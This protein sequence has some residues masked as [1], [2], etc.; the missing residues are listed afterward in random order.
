MMKPRRIDHSQGR[1]FE[2]RLSDQLNPHHELCMLASMI[3]WDILEKEFS[4]LFDA[5]DGRG[6]KPVRLIAGLMILQHMYG[7]SDEGVVAR[8]VENP[9][10]QLFC[11]YDYLQWEFPI[12]PTTLTRW[13]QRLGEGGVEKVLTVIIDTAHAVG[14]VDNSS[15]KKVIVD[16]TVACKAISYP[17]DVNLCL[18]SLRRLVK[19]ARSENI[20]LRQTYEILGPRV[21]RRANQLFR[22]RKHKLA[23]KEVK[24]LKGYCGRVYREIL[25]AVSSNPDLEKR[26]K[27][28]FFL[29][30]QLL[31]QGQEG[32]E[33]IYSLHEPHVECISKGKVHKKYEFG[34]KASIVVTHREGLVIGAQA[35]HG[36]PYDGHTLK[37]ALEQAQTLSKQKISQAF[38]D[39][40]YRGH[41]IKDCEVMCSASKKR[42]SRRQWRDMKRRQAIEPHIGHMK[43]DGKLDRNHLTGII[44][45]KLHVLLCAIGHNVRLICNYLR[46]RMDPYPV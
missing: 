5:N 42:W 40:G 32:V 33:K 17:T 36:N 38:V 18:S 4:P 35:I 2:Q 29:V 28:V 34:C 16:T 8:W 7:L 20:E 13:R 6:A 26:I 41:G 25:R 21:H 19:F 43:S 9:Y 31:L 1:L 10:W 11:G 46:R 14:M 15:F 24:R 30:G 44:G 23:M 22:Q 39:K 37:K 3:K 12:H 27:P 45:D